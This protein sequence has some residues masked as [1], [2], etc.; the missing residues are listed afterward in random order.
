MSSF[1]HLHNHSHY[2]LLDGACRIDDLVKTAQAFG[3]PA[4][5]LTDHG[6]L[7]GAIEFYKKCQ[8]AGV[9]PLVGCE[10]YVAPGNRKVRQSDGGGAG[11]SFHL[12]LL[13]KDLNGY[14]NLMKLVSAGYLEGF[15]YKPRIDKELLS[16]HHEGLVALSACLKGE[17]AWRLLH[18]GKE[19]AAAAVWEYQNLFGPDFYLEVQ[20]HSLPEED[21][22]RAGILQLAQ[23]MGVGVVA[24][25]DIHYLKRDHAEA[26]DVLLCLQTG[27]DIDDA[28]RMRYSSQEL[29]FKSGEEMAAL[30]P[31]RPDLLT[32][33]LEVADKC[34]LK[35]SFDEFH[36]PQ[37]TIPESDQPCTLDEYLQK[38][39]EAGMRERYPQVT[40]ALQARLSLELEVIKKMGYAGYFLITADFI[41]YA[42]RMNI[43]V[44]PCR[45]S[46][47][48]SLVA[49]CLR[50]TNI[51]PLR[52][53][54]LFERFL[55]PER[56]SM[57]DIDIDFCY[58]RREEVIRYVKEKY[59][60]QNVCQIITFGTMAARA[61]IRDVGRV[62][63][64]SYGDVDRIAKLVPNTLNIKLDDAIKSV[65]ELQQLEKKDEMHSRLM[66]YSRVLEGLARHAS[67]HAAG[68]VIAPGELPNYVPLY[69]TKE[70]DITT[71]YDMKSL[72][73]AGLLKMDFLGLRTLTVIQ[74][75]VDAVRRG[76][77]A[78]FDIETIPLDDPQVYRQFSNGHTIGLFQF[79]SSGMQEYLKKLQPTC[80]EDLIAMNALYRP[81][82]MSMIDDFI[83]GK[84]DPASVTY[85]HPLL[86][87]I[88]KET[89]GVAVYQEQVMRMAVEVAGFSMGGADILRRAMGK[90]SME[91][92]VEQR[93]KFIDGAGAKGVAEKTAGEIFDN[94]E[95]FAGYGFNKS[96]AACYSLV[97]Y[98]TA[99]LKNYYPAE[100][101]AA[102]ISSEMGNSDRVT[103]LLEECRRMG[104]HVLPPDVNESFA[105]FVV[106]ENGIRFGLGAVKNVGRASIEA[107][108]EARKKVGRF[109]T[110][111][112]LLLNVDTH[113]VN[114][115][116]LE[117]LVEA[118]ALDSLQGH[119]SQLFAAVETALEFSQKLQNQTRNSQA[120]MFD[121]DGDSSLAPDLPPLPLLEEWPSADLL[122]REKAILGFYLSAHP[123]DRYREE[124]ATFSTVSIDAVESRRDGTPVRIVGLISDLK[125]H[126][127]RQKRPMAFFKLE[128]FTGSLEALAFADAYEKH[129]ALIHKDAIVMVLGKISTRESEAPKIIVDEV[130]ALEDARS[131]F[132]KSLCLAMN[133]P[134]LADTDMDAIKAVLTR[135]EGTVPVY[136]RV[137]TGGKG[138]YYLRS[139]SIRVKPSLDLLES[140]RRQLG[141]ENVWVGA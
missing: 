83:R 102:T 96:H 54:L 101:M 25:N 139:K 105:D 46:A 29:Y 127:D 35:L 26:H 72:E 37:Y 79:E 91:T 141:R 136:F 132:T 60:Y 121:L 27:A 130:I 135:H 126:M 4:L 112:D 40:P 3:M 19:K 31:D 5:A 109:H 7:H 9:K 122:N 34:D 124:V 110:L 113:S 18:E 45:G 73:S 20:N 76:K 47:A 100:F 71:Q 53:D 106:T 134:D 33:T 133:L 24:T 97:A 98:Q 128:D 138:D 108:V 81:G 66:R 49:Y 114:K 12:V 39:A 42:R 86:E 22:A 116:V 84:R 63:K 104:L 59:G 119:R 21:Q 50:I 87:P 10:V 70:G 58:E 8:K 23:E 43:P 16:A 89:Y 52:Y 41:G 107:I 15:Y 92:M 82:P 120:S 32:T 65:P 85:Q 75:T 55:N 129:R 93:R 74:K 115:K 2:S 28:H 11:T 36:L 14:K 56:V 88:L 140:L 125:N 90:K 117:S 17:V 62:L 6:N 61:V 38:Q 131:R 137:Q 68:V 30:F 103:I 80:L 48:G 77:K 94:M 95:K 44:G 1:V 69:K 123:L 99:Y 51:D 13:C 78:D 67:T 111:Y 118:G 57:P 64:M